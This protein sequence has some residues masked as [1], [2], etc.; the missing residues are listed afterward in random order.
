MEGVVSC[1][2]WSEEIYIMLTS[3]EHY[4]TYI[5]GRKIVEAKTNSHSLI[6]PTM[7]SREEVDNVV[8]TA[9]ES[10]GSHYVYNSG[11][12]FMYNMMVEDLDGNV[13]EFTYMDMSKMA[14]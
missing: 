13:I 11:M 1:M 14:I 2:K 9:D 3:N 4:Q 5:N 12:D 8:K 6:S 7:S 10:G